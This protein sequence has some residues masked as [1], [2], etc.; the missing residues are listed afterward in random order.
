MVSGVFPMEMMMEKKKPLDTNSEQ[1]APE[2]GEINKKDAID[3]SVISKE[4]TE[5]IDI[6]GLKFIGRPEVHVC[7]RLLYLLLVL[8]GIVFAI[9]QIYDQVS[10]VIVTVN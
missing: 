9:Y 3:T 10:V 1:K 5:E 4:F 8:F 2:D 7:R 6:L